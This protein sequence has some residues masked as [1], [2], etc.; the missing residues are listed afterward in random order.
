MNSPDEA[1][2]S[3][4]L[5]YGGCANFLLLARACALAAAMAPT[6]PNVS[7]FVAVDKKIVRMLRVIAQTDKKDNKNQDK[8]CKRISDM[9]VACNTNRYNVT[10]THVC[11]RKR[12]LTSGANRS[13]G[14]TRTRRSF[15]SGILIVIVTFFAGSH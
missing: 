8:S 15:A 14:R 12:N 3:S 10:K 13:L 4:K 11:I 2:L 1:M 5:A 6:L 9:D 7:F